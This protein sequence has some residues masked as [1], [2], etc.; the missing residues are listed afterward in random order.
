MYRL[1][2][3]VIEQSI[4]A[5]GVPVSREI[6]QQWPRPGFESGNHLYSHPDVNTPSVDQIE[7]EITRGEATFAP[8]LKHKRSGT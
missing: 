6:L 5:L 2:G 1:R 3:F 4:D 7:E 8:L